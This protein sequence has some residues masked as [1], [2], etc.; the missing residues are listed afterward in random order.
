MYWKNPSGIGVHCIKRYE[1]RFH[2]KLQPFAKKGIEYL[3]KLRLQNKGLCFPEDKTV[4][5]CKNSPICAEM[6]N[7]P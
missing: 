5:H 2:S 1:N 4:T 7:Y 3:F 6:R